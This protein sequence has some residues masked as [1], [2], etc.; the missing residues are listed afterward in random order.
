M[1]GSFRLG[2]EEDGLTGVVVRRE[3]GEHRIRPHVAYQHD[4]LGWIVTRLGVPE[5]TLRWSLN[6]GYGGHTWDGTRDPLI[7]VLDVIAGKVPGKKHC[8]VESATGT[9]KTFLAAC[10]VLWFLACFEDSLVVTRAAK[11][12]QL[13]DN[14]WKE[15]GAL[16][17]KFKSMFP[18][19]QFTDLKIRM[20]PDGHEIEWDGDDTLRIEKWSALGAVAGV[21]AGEQSATKAQGS[22]AQHLLAIVEE[23]PGVEPAVLTAIRNTLTAPHNILL[24]LGNPDHQLDALHQLCELPNVEAVRISAF[25]HPNVVSGTEIVPGA[26]SREFIAEK[27]AEYGEDEPMYVSRV[28][29]ISPAESVHSLFRKEWLDEA[30]RKW[31][32]VMGR[33]AQG[34]RVEVDQA[35]RSRLLTPVRAIGADPANT[36]HGD[37]YALAKG[38]GAVLLSVEK[39]AAEDAHHFG[40]IVSETAQREGIQAKHIG[41]D[42]VGVGSSTVN[43]VRRKLK[44]GMQIRALEGGADEP[45]EH[46]LKAEVATAKNRAAVDLDSNRYRNGRAQWYWQLRED[47]RRGSVAL[48]FN[49]QL[50]KELLAVQYDV[51]RGVVRIEPKKAIAGRLGKSPDFADAVVYWNWVRDRPAQEEQ[52]VARANTT[53]RSKIRVRNGKL[54]RVREDES[55]EEIFAKDALVAERQRRSTLSR[56]SSQYRRP[57]RGTGTHRSIDEDILSVRLGFR[58]GEEGF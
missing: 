46:V 19:S 8:G 58:T 16:R 40:E 21:R 36:T 34:N 32:L 35:L 9:G 37:R 17:P 30:A 23:A 11:E 54:E 52:Q 45:L 53:D 12:S 20:R 1:A 57:A 48:P 29:G 3:R 25:D 31:T 33:D 4:P 7:R 5:R 55:L 13:R 47:T 24:A 15:L 49:A 51:D 38:L 44:D 28:R 39:V 43:V 6:P 2:D 14:L 42:N 26:T 56:Q 22:H 50:W 10:L 27:K 18:Q 41:I